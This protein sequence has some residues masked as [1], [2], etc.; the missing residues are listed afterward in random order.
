MARA[1]RTSASARLFLGR[2]VQ[3]QLPVSPAA[4]PQLLAQVAQGEVGKVEGP[5]P[6]QRQVCGQ[7][8]VARKPARTNPCAAHRVHR[9]LG[10]VQRPWAR[11]RAASQSAEGALV[12]RGERR[13]GSRYAPRRPEAASAMPVR[14]PVPRPQVP[15][16]ASPVRSVRLVLVEPGRPLRAEDGDVDLETLAVRG[17]AVG[18]G[19]RRR[20]AAR[21]AGRRG[22]SGR[23]GRAAPGTAG[24]RRAGGS[25]RG[26]TAPGRGRGASRRRGLGGTSGPAR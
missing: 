12:V 11:D 3:G 10:V 23:A 17:R 4:S 20:P 25:C 13:S 16:R 5:L 18:G 19:R 24:C 9:P 8:G 14:C 6:R 21:R 15:S 7:R 1:R 22:R 2:P 26:P